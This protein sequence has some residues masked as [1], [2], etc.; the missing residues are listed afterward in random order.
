[1]QQ[2]VVL[3]MFAKEPSYGDELRARLRDALGPL[4]EAMNPGHVTHTDK[5]GG[6]ERM[7]AKHRNL[8]GSS[9]PVDRSETAEGLGEPGGDLLRMVG[10][11]APNTVTR[12]EPGSDKM[13]S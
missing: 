10:V 5:H 4:G 9:E 13:A 8:R 1:M 11:L 2:E 6:Y 12:I 3:A 7:L